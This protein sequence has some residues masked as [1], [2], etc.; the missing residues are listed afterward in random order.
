MALTTEQKAGIVALRGLGNSFQTIAGEI[1]VSKDTVMKVCE[2]E[3]TS[4]LACRREVLEEVA[5]SHKLLF[6][7]RLES[8]GRFA[9]RLREE[10]ENR[11]LEEVPT[12]VIAKIYLDTLR[13]IQQQVP[14]SAQNTYQEGVGTEDYRNVTEFMPAPKVYQKSTDLI[15]RAEEALERLKLS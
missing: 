8:L 14:L 15:K 13:A 2:E 11:N 4:V 9:G 7:D 5:R 3:E 1:G 10:L 12:P 6:K